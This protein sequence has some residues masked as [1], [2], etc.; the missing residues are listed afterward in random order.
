MDTQ[1]S[2]KIEKY[3][4]LVKQTMPESKIVLFGSYARGTEKKDS[5]IDIAVVVDELNGDFL[6]ASAKLFSLTREV[7]TNIEPKL[8]V[9]KNNDSGF[10][11][12]ILKYGKVIM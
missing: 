9:K 12:S 6:A 11:E 5:D 3:A 2:Q 8:I 1:T 10:L 7:D 4:S